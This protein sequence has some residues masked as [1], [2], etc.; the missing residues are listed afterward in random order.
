M[1][2]HDESEVNQPQ[3]HLSEIPGPAHSEVFEQ[4]DN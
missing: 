2:I 4:N 3:I 1:D